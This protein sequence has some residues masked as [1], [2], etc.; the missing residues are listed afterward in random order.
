M[1]YGLAMLAFLVQDKGNERGTLSILYRLPMVGKETIIVPITYMHIRTVRR[2][3]ANE[4]IHSEQRKT[5]ISEN[6]LMNHCTCK[7]IGWQHIHQIQ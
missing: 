5:C 1:S 4:L 3:E 7:F 6:P 2:W